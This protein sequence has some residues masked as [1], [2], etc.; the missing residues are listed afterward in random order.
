MHQ[1]QLKLENPARIS[2]LNPGNTLKLIGLKKG[3]NL[4]DIGAGTGIF[5]IPAAQLTDS[6]VY[7]LEISDEMLAI[8]EEKAKTNGLN[9][10]ETMKVSDNSFG[11]MDNCIDIAIMVTVLHEIHPAEEFL[12]EIKRILKRDGIIAVI[13]FHKRETPMGP[14]VDQRMS[15]EEVIDKLGKAGF[16]VRNDINLGDNFYCLAFE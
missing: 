11:L 7:A 15:K 9:N 16:K 4:C 5:T 10:I 14:T 8:I 6:K 12:S 13:E 2:E 3:L 1:K